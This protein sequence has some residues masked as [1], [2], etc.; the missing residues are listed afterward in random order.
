MLTLIT[1]K[2]I[3]RLF[4]LEEAITRCLSEYGG[5]IQL[6]TDDRT[7]CTSKT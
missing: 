6:I 7:T 1:F 5:M 4:F 2:Y 3:F